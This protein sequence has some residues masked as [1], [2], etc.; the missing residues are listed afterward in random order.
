MSYILARFLQTYEEIKP[1]EG[2]DN[3]VMQYKPVLAPKAVHLL[4]KH[5]A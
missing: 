5:P 4:L 3:H 2:T 1:L